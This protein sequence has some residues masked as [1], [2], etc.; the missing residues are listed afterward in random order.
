ML[1]ECPPPKHRPLSALY[2][3]GHTTPGESYLDVVVG[4]Q[5][6]VRRL[7]VQVEERRGHAVQEVHAH[8]RL[9]DDAEAQIPRQRLSCQQLLQRARLHVLHDQAYRLL[10]YAIHG[11]DVAELGHLHLLGFFQK[12][13]TLPEKVRR[14]RCAQCSPSH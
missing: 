3:P 11:Q 1:T 9:M 2:R 6:D 8:S 13:P 5:Q 12:L 4:V 10:A 14:L 7:E